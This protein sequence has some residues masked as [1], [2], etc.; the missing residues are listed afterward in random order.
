[1]ERRPF[2]RLLAGCGVAAGCSAAGE[3][4][5]T[6]DDFEPVLYPPEL[7]ELAKRYDSVARGHKGILLRDEG[8]SAHPLQHNIHF[9]PDKKWVVDI[10]IIVF[11]AWPNA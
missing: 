4:H 7:S 1:M 6:A 9:S 5:S 8:W 10:G 3:A 11:V 2:F